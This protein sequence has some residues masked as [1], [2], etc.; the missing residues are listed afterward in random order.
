MS[1]GGTKPTNSI[2]DAMSANDPKRT[3]VVKATVRRCLATLV[4]GAEL[5]LIRA[6]GR[7]GLGEQCRQGSAM[8]LAARVSGAW[9]GLAAPYAVVYFGNS[10]TLNSSQ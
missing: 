9:R 1:V 4:P 2:A 5:D 8:S 7:I 3:S 6:P 10:T